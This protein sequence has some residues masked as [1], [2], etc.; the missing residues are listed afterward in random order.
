MLFNFPLNTGIGLMVNYN[1]FLGYLKCGGLYVGFVLEITQRL[2]CVHRP[3]FDLEVEY[4]RVH[5]NAQL[6]GV[7][8]L[9]SCQEPCTKKKKMNNYKSHRLQQTKFLVHNKLNNK[10][11]KTSG[12][13]LEFA[14]GSPCKNINSNILLSMKLFSKL[15]KMFITFWIIKICVDSGTCSSIYMYLN[16]PCGK[17]KPDNQ[18]ARGWFLLRSSGSWSVGGGGGAL[19][20]CLE[21]IRLAL[22][23]FSTFPQISPAHV[24]KNSTLIMRSWVQ[25][26]SCLHDS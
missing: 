25:D 11:S 15:T 19:D 13:I 12:D 18:N 16:I 8:L 6:P 9:Y 5:W 26:P 10:L 24:A 7:I 1:F 4:Q 20:C 2:L 17:K 23:S 22:I 21:V 3:G 14:S